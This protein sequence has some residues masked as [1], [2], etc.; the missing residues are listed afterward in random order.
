MG[1]LKEKENE[2]QEKTILASWRRCAG[3]LRQ[4]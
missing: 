1:E 2:E 4:T 3:L